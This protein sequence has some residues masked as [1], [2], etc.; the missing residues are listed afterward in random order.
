MALP[1]SRNTTYAIGS[2]IRSADL[3]AIQDCIIGGKHG[4][5]K[6]FI[7]A[8][9]RQPIVGGGAISLGVPTN[10]GPYYTPGA[11]TTMLIPVSDVLQV[12][13]KLYAL[14][15]YHRSGGA[16][17]NSYRMAVFDTQLNTW[18][19]WDA[20]WKL[21][22][23]DPADG[24]YVKTTIIGTAKVVAADKALYFEFAN[25]HVSDRL[26]GIELTFARE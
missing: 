22:G 23:H 8:F 15:I 10:D 26:Y 6:V 14:D 2:D 12:G 11:I 17:T 24:S 21:T 5:R 1:S 18:N 4:S 7:P 9:G 13:C 25:H 19:D 20:T 16:G 3:N